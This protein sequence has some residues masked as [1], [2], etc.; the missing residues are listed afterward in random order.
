L[1]RI[2]F[3]VAVVAMANEMATHDLGADGPAGIEL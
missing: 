3:N 1:P 2:A